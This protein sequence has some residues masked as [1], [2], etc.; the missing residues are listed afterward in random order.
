[1]TRVLVIE[2]EP[3]YVEAL[4]L[5]LAAEGFEVDSAGD[6]KAGLDAFQRRHPDVVLLDLMLPGIQGLD[7]LR[8]LRKESDVPVIVVSAKDA[9]ADI[10]SALELGADDY[11][12]KPYSI[13][14]LI[15]RVRAADRRSAA[16]IGTE[17]Y[18]LGSATLD[19]GSLKLQL[20]G[21]EHDLPK[22]EFEVLRLLM[23]RPGRVV[24]REEFLDRV[25]GFA[26]LGDTRTLDQHIRR[27]RRRLESDPDAPSIE[28]VRG[29][30]YRLVEG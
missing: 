2:D 20:A 19:A 11:V 1:M 30:G 15:A 14:E 28:T 25:W 29:V 13:R 12:T 17:V 6:G 7:V 4:E 8:L 27:L 3:S 9:E 5:S 18:T 23:E 22:K 16:G 26:W 21:A 10:V 24:S